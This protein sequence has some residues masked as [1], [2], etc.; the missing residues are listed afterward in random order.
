MTCLFY[1][2]DCVLDGRRRKHS[3][4]GAVPATRTRIATLVR[5]LPS[6][7][8]S[9]FHAVETGWLR[10]CSS[11][12]DCIPSNGQKTTGY[13]NSTPDDGKAPGS[14]IRKLTAGLPSDASSPGP[15]N[16]TAEQ[17]VVDVGPARTN[18]K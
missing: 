11:A 6:L 12:A 4:G 5:A 7:R 2:A 18:R 1:Y 15:I 16:D 9:P 13:S 17:P 8:T 3:N 10:L 14:L